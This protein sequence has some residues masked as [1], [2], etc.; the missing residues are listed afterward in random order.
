IVGYYKTRNAT[1]H[2][3]IFLYRTFVLVIGISCLLSGFFG[4]AF[5]YN[6]GVG[7]K[8]STWFTSMIG[9]SLAQQAAFVRLKTYITP[10]AYTFLTAFNLFQLVVFLLVTFF[11]PQ[12]VYVEIH[13]A[14]GML[15]TVCGIEAWLY[16]RNR[17]RISL[18][19]M[20]G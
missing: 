10:R 4:H 16:T 15:L 11:K 13:T 2:Q 19:I 20:A 18:N 6:F 8:F 12:F 3:A 14:I 1:K 5:S 7:G 17:S 9:V